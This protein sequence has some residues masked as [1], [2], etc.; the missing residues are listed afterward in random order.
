MCNNL[1]CTDICA[2]LDPSS[3]QLQ[4]PRTQILCLRC[5]QGGFPDLCL[6][7]FG[8][9]MAGKPGAERRS[10]GP[11]TAVSSLMT[12]TSLGKTGFFGLGSN[13]ARS[14]E[15]WMVSTSSDLVE[16]LSCVSTPSPEPCLPPSSPVQASGEMRQV[17]TNTLP[18]V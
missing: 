13:S 2:V 1:L 14:N 12:P 18:L 7:P 9:E 16:P 4:P 11:I 8:W 10:D 15:Q 17:I 3:I 6:E 5:F